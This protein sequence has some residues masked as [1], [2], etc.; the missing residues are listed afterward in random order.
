MV[1][2]K[3][4]E[5]CPIPIEEF[6]IDQK[7]RKCSLFNQKSLKSDDFNGNGFKKL[8]ILIDFGIISTFLMNFDPFSIDFDI[9]DGF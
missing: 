1:V 8:S 9:F 7:V 6:E 4:I 3:L 5:T 2:T